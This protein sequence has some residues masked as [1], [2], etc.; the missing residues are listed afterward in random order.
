VV[1]V[2]VERASGRVR[3]THAAIS[4]DCGLVINPDGLANQIEGGLLQGLSR[5]LYEEVRIEDGRVASL[6]WSAY[7]ILKFTDM[8]EVKTQLI[9][10]PDLPWSSAGEAG[11]V[12]CAAALCNAVFNATGKRIR[13][14]PLTPE[15]IRAAL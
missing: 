7:P 14:L 12:S 3:V 11:T 13:R 5:A 4:F 15:R 8:P 2:A 9:A 6:D 10:R 1:D